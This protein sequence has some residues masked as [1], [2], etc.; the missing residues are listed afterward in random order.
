L[1]RRWNIAGKNFF[2]CH[3]YKLVVLVFR[4][5]DITRIEETSVVVKKEGGIN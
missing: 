4:K 1:I 2:F 5:Y 3:F